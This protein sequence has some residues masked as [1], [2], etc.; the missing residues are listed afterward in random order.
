MGKWSQ[1]TVA[2]TV[3]GPLT[4][5]RAYTCPPFPLPH[6][7]RIHTQALTDT[8]IS[9][10][11]TG[12]VLH[13]A[14]APASGHPCSPGPSPTYPLGSAVMRLWGEGPRFPLPPVITASMKGVWPD[15]LTPL[16]RLCH[17]PSAPSTAP[18]CHPC[19]GAPCV[20]AFSSLLESLLFALLSTAR[21]SCPNMGMSGTPPCFKPSL[22]FHCSLDKTN[23][24][25]LY[26][27]IMPLVTL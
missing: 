11:L 10:K 19:V 20:L 26:P 3:N 25:W 22:A 24:V 12:L 17:P 9:A 27:F 2:L 14:P 7:T 8:R 5:G 15:A 1:D 4:L 16:L 18:P 6:P 21:A 13:V 23:K